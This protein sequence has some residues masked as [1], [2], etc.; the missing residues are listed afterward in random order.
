M[1]E[2]TEVQ[3]IV[4]QAARKEGKEMKAK[5]L[6]M[7]VQLLMSLLSPDLIKK[8]MDMVLDF[9]EDFVLGTASDVDDKLVLPICGMIRDAFDIPDND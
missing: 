2:E 6:T 1:V 5:L 8:F 9:V 7:L 3:K 4:A